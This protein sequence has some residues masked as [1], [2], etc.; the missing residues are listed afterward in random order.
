[1]RFFSSMVRGCGLALAW[2]LCTASP[3]TAEAASPVEFRIDA[4]SMKSALT[5]F[6]EQTG[7]QIIFS[8]EAVDTL[9]SPG[10]TGA[11]TPEAALRR[12]IAASGLRY[13]FVNPRTVRVFAASPDV[14][15]NAAPQLEPPVAVT[16][17]VQASS[18]AAN[19][20]SAAVDEAKDASEPLGEVIVTSTRQSQVSSK[21]PL[22]LVVFGSE[23]LETQGIK[24][25]DDLV[26]FSPGVTLNGGYGGGNNISIRGISSQAGAST[27]GIYIDDVPIQVRQIGYS[28]GTVFPAIFD[29]DRV[30]VLRGPQGTLFGSGSEGGTIRFI[31]AQPNLE[32]FSGYTRGEGSLTPGAGN[33]YEAGGAV[34]GPILEGRLGFRVSAFYRRDGGFMDRVPGDFTVLDD[35]GA[36]YGDAIRFTPN[37]PADRDVNSRDV[38][39]VRGALKVALG[40]DFTLTPS[41]FH[42]KGRIHDGVN[43]GFLLAASEVGAG[44]FVLPEFNAGPASQATGHTEFD[45]PNR[46]KGETELTIPSLTAEWTLGGASL[47]STTS[48]LEQKKDQY[49]EYTYYYSY[50][51][52]SLP[53]PNAGDKAISL[54]S[55]RQR[56]FTQELRLQSNDPDAQLKWVVGAFYNRSRQRSPQYIEA[57]MFFHA[58]SFFGIPSVENGDPFGPGHSNYE[59]I[60]G[61][62]MLNSSGTYFADTRSLERQLAGF[63]Q[64][65]YKL[66]ERLSLT[67]GLR[68]S[69]NKLSYSLTS[70]GPENNLNAPFGSP[71]PTP[72]GCVFGEGAFAPVF[73]GGDIHDS[74]NAVTPKLGISF[75]RDEN[76]L[77]YASASKGFR[78]GGAQLTLPSQCDSDLVDFGFV[79]ADGNPASPLTY[80]SDSVWSY[81][82][83]AKNK[84]FGGALRLATNAYVIKWKQVQTNLSLPNCGYNVIDN[85]GSATLK[86]LELAADA[87]PVRGLLLGASLSYSDASLDGALVS[88][89]G[90]VI[91]TDGSA[92]ANSGPPWTVVLNGQYSFAVGDRHDAYVRLDYTYNGRW[93]RAGQTDPGTFNFDP[94]LPRQE[95]TTLVNARLGVRAGAADVSLFAYNLLDSHP[96]ISVKHFAIPYVWTADSF[97]PRTVG[98]MASY[99]F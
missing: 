65:D 7:L 49:D 62:P 10:V 71:C 2:G 69:R 30:E 24:R 15:S 82:V 81:D 88:S 27:T 9:R 64:V 86:G 18:P 66:T 1:M 70:D 19:A 72:G 29:L 16:R 95:A 42:Q 89:G 47:Y 14:S 37:G 98:V 93:R 55:D 96:L 73:P 67:A 46:P 54:Y 21:V 23:Q 92:I 4:R 91:Y 94:Y 99:R 52:A 78:P 58:D 13:E 68:V 38:L 75:Q 45:L 56:S 80:D 97:R 59:N 40:D 85:L 26:R 3:P 50:V 8:K 12:L 84:L 79:D 87:E 32:S 22:S 57:N 90:N 43:G 20:A 83:G 63:G 28:A 33:S 76:N 77:F 39:A 61:T 74:E 17:L 41:L 48:Y 6:G 35:S 11:Y 60:W 53:V 25:F 5:Q 36:G 44:R 51:Y 31:Q 34:G